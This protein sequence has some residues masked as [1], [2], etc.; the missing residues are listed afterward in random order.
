MTYPRRRTLSM[1][2]PTLPAQDYQFRLGAGRWGV[3]PV[4]TGQTVAGDRPRA[5]TLLVSGTEGIE[6]GMIIRIDGE[7]LRWRDRQAYKC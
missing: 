4:D 7:L 2:D 6:K 5:K 1:D 3:R